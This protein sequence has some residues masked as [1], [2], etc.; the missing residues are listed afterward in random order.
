MLKSVTIAALLA[1]TTAV[2]AQARGWLPTPLAQTTRPIEN[3][4]TEPFIP[5]G[6]GLILIS[7]K[8]SA[9]Q[10]SWWA[11][12]SQRGKER[13]MAACVAM[14]ACAGDHTVSATNG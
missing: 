3:A 1:A 9:A 4:S 2:P 13:R 8:A 5:S 14:P 11:M 6:K 10:R 12:R 7:A